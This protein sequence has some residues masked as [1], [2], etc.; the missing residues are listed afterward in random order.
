MQQTRAPADGW[1]GSSPARVDGASKVAGTAL[2]IA[3]MKFPRAIDAAVVRSKV[4]RGRITGIRF[5]PSFDWSDVTIVTAQDVPCNEIAL[6]Q[7]DQPVLA[8]DQIRHVYEPIVLLACEDCA[9]LKRAAR[10]VH[11]QVEPL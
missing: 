8:K 5:D 9:K 10:H 11:V 2:Y 6:I 4:P 3:D 1:V 7:F